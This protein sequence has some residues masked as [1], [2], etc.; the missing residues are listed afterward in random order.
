MYFLLFFTVGHFEVGE[1]IWLVFK[2]NSINQTK[3][4]CSEFQPSISVFARSRVISDTDITLDY[5]DVSFCAHV[6]V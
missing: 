2:V 5:N 6:F 1:W 4:A 3:N